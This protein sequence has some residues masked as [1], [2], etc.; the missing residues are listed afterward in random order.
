MNRLKFLLVFVMGFIV[1]YLIDVQYF[2]I[3]QKEI[4]ALTQ[5]KSMG[6]IISYLITLIPLL[7]T[8]F[9]MH[10]SFEN[11]LEKLG[12]SGSLI[13]GL[14]F[15]FLVT[16]PSLVGYG[17][18][19]HI[20]TGLSVDTIIINTIS[21]ALF[22]EIIYRAFLIGQLYRYTRLGFLPS[23]IIGSTLF[24]LAHLYQST[25]INEMIGI[26]TFTFLGSLL[27]FWIYAEWEFNLWYA[28]FLHSLM[29]LYWL[30][31]DVDNN[32]LGGIYANIIRFTTVLLTIFGTIFYKRKMKIP[33][34]IAGSSWWIKRK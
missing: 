34:E 2:S 15:A 14:L 10:G 26:F 6:H 7:I 22:E 17:I 3:L 27:F 20:N 25:E 13:Q 12:L 9:V 11:I 19:F 33:F 28:I 24:G 29:N 23:I 32:A 31:F 30:I 21:S 5:S 8:V 18:K 4:T 1:Y 16:L